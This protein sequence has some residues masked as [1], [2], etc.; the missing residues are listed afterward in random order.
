MSDMSIVRLRKRLNA[1][2]SLSKDRALRAALY[3]RWIQEFLARNE[4]EK[5]KEGDVQI[6]YPDEM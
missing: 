6:T 3:Q 4:K 2:R 1:G 5:E